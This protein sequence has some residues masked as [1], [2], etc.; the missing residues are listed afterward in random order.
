M[1]TLEIPVLTLEH[2]LRYDVFPILF[3]NL[4]GV[5]GEW[6]GFDEDWLLQQVQTRRSTGSGWIQSAVDIMAWHS[7]GYMI[8]PLWN[9]VKERLNGGSYAGY[10]N[11][12]VD[13]LGMP[14]EC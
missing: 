4:L 3:P 7:A 6:A 11:G 8:W 13:S 1:R 10:S 2:I 14:S 5:S 9:K 12:V